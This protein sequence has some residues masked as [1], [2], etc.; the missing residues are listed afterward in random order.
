LNTAVLADAAMR[1]FVSSL[2]TVVRVY[3]GSSYVVVDNSSGAP[4]MRDGYPRPLTVGW[5]AIAHLDRL[6]AALYVAAEADDP[7]RLY[8]FKVL[9]R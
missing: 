2:W 5:P 8:L 1:P 7:A 4:T 6:D 9:S 3:A